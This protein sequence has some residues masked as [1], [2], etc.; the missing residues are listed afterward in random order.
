MLSRAHNTTGLLQQ[1]QW[2][3]YRVSMCLACCKLYSVKHIIM[4]PHP[5]YMHA[6]IC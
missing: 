5:L 2:Q 6:C 3:N 1:N 4:T